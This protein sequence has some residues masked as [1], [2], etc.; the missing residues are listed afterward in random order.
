MELI[1]S[2]LDQDLSVRLRVSG[3]SMAPFLQTDDAVILA[4]IQ[5]TDNAPAVGDLIFFENEHGRPVLHRI[6][7][8]L[9]PAPDGTTRFLTQGDAMR[10]PD[11]PV[12][13]SRVLARVE[14]I[15]RQRNGSTR[16]LNLRHPLHRLHSRL[17][18]W[19][20]RFRSL[21]RVYP[22]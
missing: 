22:C 17:K 9:S 18:A 2:L 4:A 8:R 20:R 7:R 19:H 14:A 15:E 13:A 6:L 16:Y 10:A 5:P 3:V 11:I 12:A 21:I 1:R